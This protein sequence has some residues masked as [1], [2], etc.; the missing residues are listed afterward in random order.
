MPKSPCTEMPVW[1]GVLQSR[2]SLVASVASPSERLQCNPSQPDRAM[3]WY[4]ARALP[5]GR[6][7]PYVVRTAQPTNGQQ[8]IATN[9]ELTSRT[10]EEGLFRRLTY[11]K[12]RTVKRLVLQVKQ[13]GS[14]LSVPSNRK[15]SL[16]EA[17]RRHPGL[18]PRQTL[19]KSVRLY[20]GRMNCFI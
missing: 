9:E 16:I 13:L 15:R 7:H 5:G 20:H 12:Y 4:Q 3:L 11:Q 19:Q 10:H 14:C 6:L 2:H 17:R 18:A 1:L 8:P